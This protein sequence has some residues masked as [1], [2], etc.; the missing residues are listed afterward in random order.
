MSPPFPHR[1]SDDTASATRPDPER[2]SRGSS[3][4]ITVTVANRCTFDTTAVTGRQ[5]REKA[6]VPPGFAL[7]R[8]TPD[9]NEPIEDDEP[10]DLR[11]GDH[12]FARPSSNAS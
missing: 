5:I 3:A 8:R 10:I 6:G 12:F 4:Q 2:E 7:F 11:G 1:D 9:G